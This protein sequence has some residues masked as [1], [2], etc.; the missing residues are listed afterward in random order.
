MGVQRA[1]GVLRRPVM[2]LSLAALL[3]LLP[4]LDAAAGP[5]WYVAGPMVLGAAVSGCAVGACTSTR[6]AVLAVA[7]MVVLLTLANQL[8]G[9][10]YH[11]LDDAA[12]FLFVAGGPAV[13]GALVSARAR[14]VRE[15][16]RLV[17]ALRDQRL[18]EV[19]AARLAEQ[20]R[21]EQ[22]VHRGISQRVG[23]IALRAEGARRSGSPEDAVAALAEVEGVARG[24][25]DQLREV[26]GTLRTS[27]LPADESADPAEEIPSPRPTV[28][29]LDLA[30]AVACGAGLAVETLLVPPDAEPGWAVAMS[31]LVAAPLAWRRPHPLLATAGVGVLGT[32]MSLWLAPLTDLVTPVALMLLASYAV[33]AWCRGRWWLVGLLVPWTALLAFL[34][35]G[36]PGWA[37]VLPVVAFATAAVALGRVVA[38]WRGRGQR[39]AGT[40]AALER[41]RG[42]DLR[43]AVA[44]QRQSM[45]SALHDSVAHA[46]TVVCVQAGA[47][48]RVPDPAV[49]DQALGRIAATARSGLTELR[50]GLAELEGSAGVLDRDT[51]SALAEEIGVAAEVRANGELTLGRPGARLVLRV[52]REALVNVARHAPGAPARVVLEQ[53]GDTI[54][55]EVGDH[56]EHSGP[57]T[58][59]TGTGLVGLAAELRAG[60]GTLSWGTTAAGGFRVRA[61]VPLEA[62]VDRRTAGLPR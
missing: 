26:L 12:F 22:E 1:G 56:G 42:A 41:G 44:R 51:I 2:V 27:P 10:E 30:I 31:F 50:T 32:A 47:G 40:V 9:D 29:A 4:L 48:Q 24:A 37:D 19:E 14:Q 59:G 55:L 46:M 36:D 3:C 7:G 16:T 62:V 15:L 60:G 45:A 18:V 34:A 38:S 23:A 6:T 13:A 28:G 39:I 33:G 35:G 20:T 21:V 61:E 49:V 57:G 25:L 53:V 52:L 43:W 54:R 5:G 58:E 8:A 17:A 11:W